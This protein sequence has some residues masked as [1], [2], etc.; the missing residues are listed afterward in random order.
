MQY[1]NLCSSEPPSAQVGFQG[2]PADIRFILPPQQME[3]KVS[4]ETN[5]VKII[6]HKI[7]AN[8]KYNISGERWDLNGSSQHCL[9]KNKPNVF[10]KNIEEIVGRIT[11]KIAHCLGNPQ[12][13]V[14]V[15]QNFMQ[16]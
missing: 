10:R 14:L 15:R 2:G 16:N 12:V 1:S 3:E 4:T 7:S 8:L 6:L 9:H 5:H 13:S 11:V